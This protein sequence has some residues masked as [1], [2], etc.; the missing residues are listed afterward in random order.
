[1]K[2]INPFAS[3]E[4]KKQILGDEGLDSYEEVV[5][6]TYK[7]IISSAPKIPK[8]VKNVILDASALSK[9]DKESK[10]I[11]LNLSLNEIMTR[12]NKE[13]G[14]DLQVDFSSMSRTM[15]AVSDPK[16]RR[17]LELYLSEIFQSVRPILI[18]HMITKLSLAIDYVLDPTRMFGGELQLTDIWV[19][20]EK[21]LQYIQQ[22]EEMKNEILIKGSDIELRKLGESKE[23]E[24]IGKFSDN[25]IAQDF[26]K[27]FMKDNG[28]TE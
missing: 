5:E 11:E 1:M 16:Q 26:M 14:T 3:D 19:S 22:L 18:L 12:Y 9:Q 20:I 8:N 6:D 2:S 10:A 27:L 7:N 15:V 21:I 17:T 28:I 25:P 4:F 13:Y 23:T 24:S